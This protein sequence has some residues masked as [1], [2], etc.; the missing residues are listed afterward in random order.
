[1]A[2]TQK[3]KK[4]TSK[5]STPLYKRPGFIVLFL[6]IFVAI[7]SAIVVTNAQSNPPAKSRRPQQKLL[8]NYSDEK[9]SIVSVKDGVVTYISRPRNIDV[10]A[11]NSLYCTPENNG[12]ITT[13]RLNSD[14]QAQ[15]SLQIEKSRSAQIQDANT[16]DTKKVNSSRG[17]A[18]R[19]GGSFKNTRYSDR[20]TETA[21][22]KQTADFLESLCNKPAN[23]IKEDATPEIVASRDASPSLAQQTRNLILPKANAGGVTYDTTAEDAQHIR[24]AQYRTQ[25]RLAATTRDNCLDVWAR[26]WAEQM[27]KDRWL[28]HSNLTAQYYNN[29]PAAPNGYVGLEV[30]FGENIGYWDIPVTDDPAVSRDASNITFNNFINSP[31]HNSNMLNPIWQFHGMGAYKTADKTKIYIVQAFRYN[32]GYVAPVTK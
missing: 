29:C 5:P 21:Y 9:P 10:T 4:I 25:N 8:L 31:E 17:L 14:E 19:D 6:L 20:D 2:K 7:G 24:L 16:T 11:D 32:A 1:M 18:I 3:K 23:Q 27:A 15:V 28:R 30:R 22:F 13:R 26:R 12:D